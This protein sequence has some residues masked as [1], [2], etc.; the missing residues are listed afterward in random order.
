MPPTLLLLGPQGSK[1]EFG[2]YNFYAR[3]RPLGGTAPLSTL[4]E[5]CIVQP[6][7]CGQLICCLAR[8]AFVS[9]QDFHLENV[10][11]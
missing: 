5:V 8:D 6:I 7:T 11:R 9:R 2:V 3:D 1:V 4:P 10:R